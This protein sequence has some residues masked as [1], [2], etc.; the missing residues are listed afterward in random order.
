MSIN[1]N[2][3]LDKQLRERYKDLIIYSVP[4]FGKTKFAKIAA[5]TLNGVYVDLLQRVKKD[6]NIVDNIDMFYPEDFKNYAHKYL[7]NEKSFMMV[8]NMDFLLNTWDDMQFE[9]FLNFVEKDE[10]PGAYCF[11]MQYRNKLNKRNILNTYN[12]SRILDLYE[13]SIKGVVSWH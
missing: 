12:E 4:L 10:T 1:F 11:L 6:K 13:L 5:K 3:Y 2:E 8:D 7:I 9:E